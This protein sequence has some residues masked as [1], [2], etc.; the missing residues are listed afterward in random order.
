[1]SPLSR[2]S[3][4]SRWRSASKPARAIEENAS[5]RPSGDGVGSFSVP[6]R[7][8]VRFFGAADPSTGT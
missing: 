4:I 3:T 1:M 8:V 5:Q 7:L 6:G 2:S